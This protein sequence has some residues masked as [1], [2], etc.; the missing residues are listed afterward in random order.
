[1]KF[2]KFTKRIVE[3]EE[4]AVTV[5]Y[6]VLTAVTAGL[7]IAARYMISSGVENLTGDIANFLSSATVKTSF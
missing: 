4:G 6:V 2:F 5:D 7:G 1:M 3:D